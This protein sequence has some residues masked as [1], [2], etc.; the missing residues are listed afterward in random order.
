MDRTSTTEVITLRSKGVLGQ[1][2]ETK[3]SRIAA[4]PRGREIVAI[5]ASADAIHRRM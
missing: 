4:I 1:K 3:H 2:R 5:A